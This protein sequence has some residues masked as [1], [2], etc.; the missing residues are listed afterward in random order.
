[1]K[2]I[3]K[4]LLVLLLFS[5]LITGCNKNKGEPPSLPPVESMKIDFS[6]FESG[7]KSDNLILP[8]GIENSNWEFAAL[9]A[10]YWKTIIV[11]T[12]AVPVLAFT[13]AFN[14]TPVYLD[15]KTWQWSYNATVLTVTYKAR[16]TGQIRNRSFPGISL[17]RGHFKT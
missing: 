9:V 4:L 12:L 15:D 2:K 11:S 1:M 17:V 5:G 3:F 10:G 8:K 13:T 7:K 6:N 16:L 14:Q